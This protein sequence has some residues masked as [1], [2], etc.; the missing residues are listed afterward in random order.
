MVCREFIVRVVSCIYNHLHLQQ[1]WIFNKQCF[2]SAL[3][4]EMCLQSRD[5]KHKQPYINAQ[6]DKL[7][8]SSRYAHQ[9]NRY[10]LVHELYVKNSGASAVSL[11]LN[12]NM[13]SPSSDIKFVTTTYAWGS[14]M[15]GNITTPGMRISTY[16]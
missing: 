6:H 13:G 8:P 9:V 14:V 10:L 5:G 12:L 16:T 7:T 11:D 1:H 4:L 15:V 3:I 2:T